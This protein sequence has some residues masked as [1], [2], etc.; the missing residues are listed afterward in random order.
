[1]TLIRT[2]EPSL[3]LPSWPEQQALALRTLIRANAHKGAFA[4]FDADNTTYQHDLVGAFLPFLEQRGVLGRATLPQALQIIPFQDSPGFTESLNSYYGRLGEIDDQVGYPWASQVFSG[5]TLRELK[6]HL[7]ALLAQEQPIAA[8]AIV[9]GQVQDQLHTVPRMLRGQQE[10]FAALR[11]HGIEV[12]VV[13]AAAEELVRMIVSDPRYGYHVKPENVIGVS[14]ALKNR[15][16][17][18]LTTARKRIALGQYQAEDLLDHELTHTLWAPMPWYEGKYAAIRSYIH[19]WKRPILVAGD[20]PQSDGPMFFRGP[21]VGA[22]SLR[23]FMARGPAHWQ[24]MRELQAEHAQAQSEQGL[25][26][27]ADQNWIVVSPGELA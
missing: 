14:L 19:K 7:D 3:A 16:T 18:E 22:G 17:H 23:L 11:E 6:G 24:K 2:H 12:F 13:S 8:Q 20:T 27:T 4:V 5:Q 1:M 25:P 10:L 21:D 26:I 15:H 9:N